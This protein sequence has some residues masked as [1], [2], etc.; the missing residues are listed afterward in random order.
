[1]K[2]QQFKRCPGCRHW[3]SAREIIEDPSVVPIG[4]HVDEGD[5]GLNLF[6]F[7][8]TTD[9][10]GTTFVV[11]VEKFEPFLTEAAPREALIG[12]AGCEDHCTSVGELDACGQECRFAPFR[13]F[14]LAM[15]DAKRKTV[16]ET[17]PTPPAVKPAR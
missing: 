9:K 3:F 5:I 2:W 14:L 6:Y 11:E 1:M 7:N 12:T 8:H 13:R 17:P 10:C 16:S 4:M 15:I